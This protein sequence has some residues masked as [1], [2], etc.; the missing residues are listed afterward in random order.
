ML[1]GDVTTT[2]CWLPL[3]VQVT[4]SSLNR[5]AVATRADVGTSKAQCLEK[6]F[7][8]IVPEVE[9]VCSWFATSKAKNGHMQLRIITCV[10]GRAVAGSSLHS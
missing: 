5:H 2:P 3:Q 8:E 7:K 10:D 1:P 4:L 9:R 6:H